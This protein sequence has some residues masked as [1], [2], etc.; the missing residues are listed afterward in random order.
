MNKRLFRKLIK[1]PVQYVKDSKWNPFAIYNKQK[2]I[3]QGTSAIKKM[4]CATAEMDKARLLDPIENLDFITLLKILKRHDIAGVYIDPKDENRKSSICILCDEK[5]DFII[6][7]CKMA[8]EEAFVI[9]YKL[10]G[11]VKRGGNVRE[12]FEDINQ[13]NAIDI[14][15][16]TTRTVLTNKG[17]IWFRVEF[18]QKIENTYIFPVTN[19]ISTKLW[20]STVNKYQLFKGGLIDYSVILPYQ[21]EMQ[22]NFDIDIVYTWV[23]SNDEEWKKLY[24]QYRPDVQTDASSDARFKSRD[25]LKYSLRS[26][27]L[28]GNFFRNIYIVSNCN[29]PE[30]LNLDNKRIKWIYHEDILPNE[31][32]PTFSSHA[33]ETSL[34][35]IPDLSEF[36]VYCNDDVFLTK[37]VDSTDFFLSNKISKIR[38]EKWGNVNG[39]P[40]KGDPDF[41]N[42][43]RN[44]RELL[45]KTFNISCVALHSH[46]VFPMRKTI[47]EEISE[48]YR[49]EVLNTARQRFRSETDISLTSFLYPHYAYLTGRAINS[50]DK[51]LL[52]K[53]TK[54]FK[55]IFNDLLRDKD[56]NF[57]SLPL[58]ICINDGADSYKNEVW[59]EE[60][61]KFLN[62]FFPAKSSFEK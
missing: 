44:G 21:Q 18:L 2:K 62:G 30:W 11:K 27:E 42:A 7:L 26:W 15:L 32:L 46:T 49:N 25:E 53:S 1:H 10:A 22:R 5:Y 60:V 24:Q 52:V 47:V 23:N 61:V 4:S 35:K 34:H 33:I 14:R 50:D 16:S 19:Q 54:N 57:N 17:R 12:I 28:Y 41:L 36:F 48:R 58:T 43:A 39:E 8:Y 29:P 20:A 56:S 37:R 6:K 9:S 13:Q 51:V 59:N 40:T 31:T 3:A 38:L 45:E 55:K